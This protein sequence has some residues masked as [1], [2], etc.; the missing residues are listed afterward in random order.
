MRNI[1]WSAAALSLTICMTAGAETIHW[2]NAQR[3]HFSDAVPSASGTLASLDMG[4][5]P[6][7]GSSRLFS[8]DELRSLAALAHENT[9]GLDIPNDVRVRRA[10]RL[11]SEQ[12]LDALIRPALSAL[13]P[14]G[15]SLKGLGLPKTLV[16]VPNIQ[17]G[18]IQMPRLP[19]HSGMTHITPTIEL[20]AGGALIMRLP[21]SADLQLDERAARYALE[22]GYQLNLV[23]DTGATRIS[24]TAVLMTPADIGDIVPC[25]V[26]NTRKVL[27]ARVVTLS[28]AI[29]VRP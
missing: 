3:I 2:V 9:D 6:P 23:I 26:V 8:K 12:D 18:D 28:E 19:K 17:V 25:Q 27:R 5:A 24:A 16:A 1:A 10:T 13:L 22:R 14:P 21:V 15:A 4:S 29:V 7:P 20:V 11:L